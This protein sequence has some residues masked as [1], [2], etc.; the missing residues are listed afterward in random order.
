MAIGVSGPGTPGA[1]RTTEQQI[2]DERRRRRGQRVFERMPDDTRHVGALGH[3]GS[4]GGIGEGREA[5]PERRPRQDRAH[6]EG[7][8]RSEGD[9]RGME[10]RPADEERP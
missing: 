3:G 2:G 4:D 6:E 1:G 9:A 8:L 10:Q 7:R 5:V